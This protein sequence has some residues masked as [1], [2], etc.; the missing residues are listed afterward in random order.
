VR[1][2]PGAPTT[3][4]DLIRLAAAAVCVVDFFVDDRSVDDVGA[5]LFCVSG[6]ARPAGGAPEP[7]YPFIFVAEGID[8]LDLHYCYFLEAFCNLAFA[9]LRWEERL[10]H[11]R[12]GWQLSTVSYSPFR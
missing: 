6:L 2:R 5:G 7:I 11:Q 8:P 3:S 1:T 12:D 9:Q 10:A 4:R